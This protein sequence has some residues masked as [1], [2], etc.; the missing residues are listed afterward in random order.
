MRSAPRPRRRAARAADIG[1][2][3]GFRQVERA[4]DLR[5]HTRQ[6]M[7]Q[8]D[9]RLEATLDGETGVRG[10]VLAVRDIH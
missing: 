1:A 6:V 10:F 3:L 2:R 4:A 8:L 5:V 9:D 7:E